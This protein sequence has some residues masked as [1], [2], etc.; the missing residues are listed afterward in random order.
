MSESSTFESSTFE[1]TPSQPTPSASA[2]SGPVT[3][4]DVLADGQEGAEFNGLFVRKGSIAAF[5]AN[6]RA[7]ESLDP[8]G[9]EYRAVAAEIREL[10][11]ALDALGLFDVLSVRNPDVAAVLASAAG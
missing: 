4:R 5:L 9:A 7:L 6:A 2:P 8:A 11:P 1:P 10:G 3:A